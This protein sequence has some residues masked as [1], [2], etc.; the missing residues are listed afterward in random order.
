[1]SGATSL[2]SPTSTGPEDAHIVHTSPSMGQNRT[3]R[4][5]QAHSRE[6]IGASPPPKHTAHMGRMR[7]VDRGPKQSGAA[8]RLGFKKLD[9][10]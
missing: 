3:T 10:T 2:L 4:R 6:N 1:M 7:G 9:K 5:C 8:S